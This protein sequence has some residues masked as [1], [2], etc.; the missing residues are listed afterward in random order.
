MA[1]KIV[2]FYYGGEAAQFAEV[3]FVLA[4]WMGVERAP[5]K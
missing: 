4:L 2:R 1:M 5:I 3:T